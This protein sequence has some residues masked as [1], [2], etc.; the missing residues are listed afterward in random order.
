MF[1]ELSFLLSHNTLLTNSNHIYIYKTLKQLAPF[2]VQVSS[3]TFFIHVSSL[4]FNST[5]YKFVFRNPPSSLTLLLL[6]ANFH[7]PL[8]WSRAF[9]HS[10]RDLALRT[11]SRHEHTSAHTHT[12]TYTYFHLDE[13]RVAWNTHT[14]GDRFTS[15]QESFPQFCVSS[16][17]IIH[18]VPW[19]FY[20]FHER[21]ARRV[22]SKSGGIDD[23]PIRDRLWRDEEGGEDEAKQARIALIFW[24]D[25]VLPYVNRVKNY[26][27]TG[28]AK[29]DGWEW[30]EEGEEG[31][32]RWIEAEGRA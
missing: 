29:F 7:P 16:T 23:R 12:H 11:P 2:Q 6:L 25:S 19:N 20:D 28:N 17:G 13:T 24:L 26:G 4:N 8:R 18:R 14:Q 5:R 31:E 9:P 1:I 22:Q 10:F 32:I 27:D 15:S 30:R 21:R 3:P